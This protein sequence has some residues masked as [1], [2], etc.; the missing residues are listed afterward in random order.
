M[1]RIAR[2]SSCCRSRPSSSPYPLCGDI[3][4]S[5]SCVRWAARD[6][7]RLDPDLSKLRQGLDRNHAHRCVPILLRLSALRDRAA[8]QEGRLLRLL[9]LWRCPLSADPGGSCQRRNA[10]LLHAV[11]EALTR[12]EE[13]TSE[14][15]SL[16]RISYA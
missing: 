10:K 13:H 9:L 14:L 16:M 7:A 1:P 5:R 12:S 4:N 15:Q 8:A 3:S 6:A 11:T 2:Q